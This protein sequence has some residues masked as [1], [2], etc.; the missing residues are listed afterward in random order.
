MGC[1]KIPGKEKKFVKRKDKNNP[2]RKEGEALVR[3][4]QGRI[5]IT[6]IKKDKTEK[7]NRIL[8]VQIVTKGVG[9]GKGPE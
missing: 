5:S 7:K 1:K 4:V 6:E 2:R 9:K 3:M 8:G